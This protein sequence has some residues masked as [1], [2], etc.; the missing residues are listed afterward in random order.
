MHQFLKIINFAFTFFLLSGFGA[1][2][3]GL[4]TYIPYK[5]MDKWGYCDSNKKIL[6]LPKWASADFFESGKAKVT[7]I[8][9]SICLI[10][11]L[12]NYIIPASRRWTGFSFNGIAEGPWLNCTDSIGK[13]GIVDSKNNLLIPCAY[14]HPEPNTWVGY[15]RFVRRHEWSKWH[16]MAAKNGKH[17][18]VGEHNETLVSFEYDKIFPSEEYSSTT[19]Y[20]LVE[21]N[22]KQG[23]VDTNNKLIV[24]CIYDHVYLVPQSEYKYF[25]VCGEHTGAIDADG[26]IIVPLVYDNVQYEPN[27]I[28]T[29]F[30]T[31]RKESGGWRSADGKWV[32]EG[33]YRVRRINEDHTATIL[34]T[35][36]NGSEKEGLA[37]KNGKIVIKPIYDN[38]IVSKDVVTASVSWE[39]NDSAY[40]KYKVFSKKNYKA[41]TGWIVE[42]DAYQFPQMPRGNWCGYSNNFHIT[43]PPHF[44][45][46]EN[47]IYTFRKDSMDYT[48]T[49]YVTGKDNRRTID[50]C[51]GYYTVTSNDSFSAVVDADYNY[52][53]PPQKKY[54]LVSGDISENAFIVT[55]NNLYGAVDSNLRLV[56]AFQPRPLNKAFRWN[57]KWYGMTKSMNSLAEV[58]VNGDGS[59]QSNFKGRRIKNYSTRDAQFANGVIYD[60]FLVTDTT[61]GNE[62]IIGANNEIAYPRVSFKYRQMVGTGNGYFI[63]AE[64]KHGKLVDKH[65]HEPFP[66][67]TFYTAHPVSNQPALLQFDYTNKRETSFFYASKRGILYADGIRDQK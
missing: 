44:T 8:D 56:V 45:K 17:G 19:R 40:S 58:L 34:I 55:K 63:V 1:A 61:T 10:D 33:K 52:I 32:I 67:V 24:P 21:K 53:I 15:Y 9:K 25:I 13:W 28:Y 57:N 22:G 7:G 35:D 30:H 64:N 11:T 48:V 18:I 50:G 62:G 51:G 65:D 16:M 14:D 2:A 39:Q 66:G 3:Q 31:Y 26:R 27:E 36:A 23:V 49:G 5:Y 43:K 12:G 20:F 54:H 46:G 41:I 60:Y 4:P 59:V 47:D 38:I 37:D 42:K 29:G 6:L